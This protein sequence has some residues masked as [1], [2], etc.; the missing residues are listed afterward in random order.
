MEK[1][2][3][4]SNVEHLSANLIIMN[5]TQHFRK[6]F[7]LPVYTTTTVPKATTVFMGGLWA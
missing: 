7:L 2:A 5:M 1:C 4:K 6:T 3:N